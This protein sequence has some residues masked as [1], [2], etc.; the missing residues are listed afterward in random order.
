MREGFTNNTPQLSEIGKTWG[1]HPDNESFIF[2]IDPILIFLTRVDTILIADIM[3]PRDPFW[4]NF[5]GM[6]IRV[7]QLER[8]SEITCCNQST[9]SRHA[10][11]IQ[12]LSC[13][14]EF[15]LQ[16]GILYYGT[17]CSCC[18]FKSYFI[19]CELCIR[20]RF[21][22]TTM[23]LVEVIKLIEQIH[24]SF[25][26]FVKFKLYRARLRITLLIIMFNLQFFNG[27]IQQHRN[28]SC[29]NQSET[30]NK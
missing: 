6:R 24:W 26:R 14:T 22:V 11:R 1:S 20:F 8:I 28:S 13:D 7:N 27:F 12:R 9:R 18:F 17:T 25:E 10:A 2:H 15:R 5:N 19:P 23:I 16:I 3:W 29:Y 30:N 21:N 4:T